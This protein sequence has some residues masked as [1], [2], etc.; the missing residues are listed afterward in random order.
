MKV[1]HL[2]ASRFFGGPERQM[3]ELARSLPASVETAFVSFSEDGLCEKFLDE[4][5]HG[6]FEGICLPHD[7]PRLIA[8]WRELVRLLRELKADVLCCHGYKANL[9]GLLAARRL[10][11]PAISVSRG[12]TGETLRVRLY[13]A[14]DRFLLKR[15]DRVISVSDGQAEKVHRIGVAD[16]KTV[17]IR[18]AIRTERFAQPDPVYRERLESLF[19][20]RPEWIVGAAGR[21]SPEKSFDVLIDAAAEV[22][23]EIPRVGFVLFGEGA[24]HD[25]LAS[26]VKQHGLEGRFI[27]AGFRSDLDQYIPH[28]DLLALS[29]FTEGLPNVV[30]ETLA[31]GVPVVAT[32]VGGVPEV[33]DHGV[34]GYCVEPGRPQDLARGIADLLDDDL[35]RST[36]GESGQKRV[37]EEFTF[38]V[39]AQEYCKL[40]EHLRKELRVSRQGHQ[41]N[42]S[43]PAQQTV[44]RVVR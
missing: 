28:F 30:L 43:M 10:H 40:F 35:L 14:L 13:E 39:Q 24:L 42:G 27:L 9:L 6:G 44:H 1:V 33:V 12:W 18:N 4:V 17:V 34:S 5:R 2:T 25:D 32:A 19:P 38:D 21:L 23:K 7:T 22:A 16:D 11:V 15:M 3:F 20:D 26:R 36:M 31:S 8:A 37:A 41:S 29:S